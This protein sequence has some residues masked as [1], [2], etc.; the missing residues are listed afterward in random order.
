MWHE[1][2]SLIDQGIPIVVAGNFN[3]ITDPDDKRGGKLF[4]EDVGPRGLRE[5][6][7]DL[8][9]LGFVG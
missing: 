1:V 4:V 7:S 9:D 2:A 5:F 6:I 3:C 8:V